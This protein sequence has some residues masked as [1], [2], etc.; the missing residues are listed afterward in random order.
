MMKLIVGLGNPGEKYKNNRHNIGYLFIDWLTAN[1][2]WPESVVFRKSE[3]FMNDSGETVAKLRD[4]YKVSPRDIFVVHDDLDIRVG[5]YKIQMGVGPKVHYGLLS[6][7]RMLK[8]KDFWRVRV[9]VDGRSQTNRAPGEDYVLEDFTL[10]E[11]KTVES[12]F[13]RIWDEVKI[14]MI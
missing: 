13:S 11:M 9:G 4:F 1:A 5:E 8:T 3:E 12:L 10:E 6:V 14:K 7:E 2:G